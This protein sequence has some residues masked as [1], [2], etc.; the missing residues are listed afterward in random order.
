MG[1]F[2]MLVHAAW[3][4]ERFRALGDS[5]RQAD[6]LDRLGD[7]AQGIGEGEQALAFGPDIPK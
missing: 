4:L 2:R 6:V 7:L 5:H 3:N 1:L